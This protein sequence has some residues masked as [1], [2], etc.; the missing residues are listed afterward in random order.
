MIIPVKFVYICYLKL[1]FLLFYLF[2]NVE[3]ELI[4]FIQL[5]LQQML[6]LIIEMLFNHL[7]F[8]MQ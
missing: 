8:K 3:L 4:Y 2:S 6:N 5:V 7:G 1:V